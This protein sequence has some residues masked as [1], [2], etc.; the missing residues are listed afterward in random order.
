VPAEVLAIGG[1]FSA[2]RKVSTEPGQLHIVADQA[3]NI[4]VLKMAA[5][6]KY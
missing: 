3:L 6:G 1:P 4:D 5:S 2:K